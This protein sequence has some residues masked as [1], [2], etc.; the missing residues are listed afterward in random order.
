MERAIN[1]YLD[2]LVAQASNL[3]LNSVSFRGNLR[4][5][6]TNALSQIKPTAACNQLVGKVTSAGVE[7]L[8]AHEGWAVTGGKEA[9]KKLA[10]FIASVDSLRAEM[11]NCPTSDMAQALGLS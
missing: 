3:A 10:A 2:I 5:L 1:S 7:L 6:L 11:E 8:Q 4:S 9:D